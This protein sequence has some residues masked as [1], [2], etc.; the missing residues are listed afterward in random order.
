MIYN[1]KNFGA[2]PDG[3]TLN[4]KAIQEAIDTCFE[5]GGG[6]GVEQSHGEYPKL[7]FCAKVIFNNVEF[8][9]KL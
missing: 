5:N 4:T 7:Q 1:I 8:I 3:A 6:Q 9:N 2:V